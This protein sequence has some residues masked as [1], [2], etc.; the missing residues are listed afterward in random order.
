MTKKFPT[1]SLRR[2]T[3]LLALTLG[4]VGLAQATGVTAQD[5]PAVQDAPAAATADTTEVVIVGTRAGLRKA[6]AVKR[7]SDQFVDSVIAEDIGKLPDVNVA[8][9]LQRVSGVQ[10]K[11]S[12]GEGTQVSIRGLTQNITLVNGR[13]VVDSAGRGGSGV[14]SLGTGSYGLLAQLPSEIIQRL[15]VTKLAAASDIEGALSGTVNIVT[16]KP[17]DSKS[18]TIAF[19]AEGLY[20]NRAGKGGDRTSILFT[21]HFSDKLAG[22]INLSQSDRNIRDESIFS[23]SGYVPLTGAG[24]PTGAYYL[25]DIR[26]TQ[27]NDNR[28]RT[29]LNA[30]LQWRPTDNIEVLYDLLYSKQDIDRKRWWFALPLSSNYGAYTNPVFSPANTL[31]AGSLSASLQTNTETY[32]NSGDT[33]ATGLTGTWK[34]ERLKI[35]GDASYS[36]SQQDGYQQ[37]LR[38]TTKTPSVIAFDFRG[39]DVP[40]FTVPGS[41]NL[42]D[43]SQFNFTNYFDNRDT[44]DS[45]LSAVRLD[46][47]YRLDGPFSHLKFG[48][49]TSQL[50]VSIVKYQSQLTGP[51]SADTVPDSYE[52]RTL[53]ILNGASGYSPQSALYPV[54]FGGGKKYAYDVHGYAPGTFT[55]YIY[56]PLASFDTSEKNTAYYVQTDIDT[57]LFGIPLSGNVGVRQVETKFTAIGSYKVGSN[58]VQPLTVHKD[59]SKTLPS[60]ALKASV[61]DN[62]LIRFGAAKV[63]ARPNS[64]D[65]NPG[66]NLSTAAPFTASA[67]NAELN[68]FEATQYDLSAEYYFKP[69]SIVSLGLFKKDLQSFIIK[70]A[71]TETY[72]GIDYLVTRPYNG[73]DATIDGAEFVYQD[74]FDFLPA[75]FDGLGMVANISIINSDTGTKSVRTG[76]KIPVPGL[77]K[78]NFNLVLYYEKAGYGVRVAYNRRDK[79]LDQLGA[80]GEPIYFDAGDDLAISGRVQITPHY[81][82]DAQIS[83]VLD[84][85]IRKYGTEEVAT[86]SYALNGRTFSIA[87]RGKF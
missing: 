23:F 83:N 75:P 82:L 38:M 60:L 53:D 44:A 18:D 29:G 42:T 86:S 3:S 32:V 68:P 31:L 39:V 74:N 12:L 81:S 26:D 17:L 22:L 63:I 43:P 9:S 4:V 84:S 50:D 59:Y 79:F 51:T 36:R 27:I 8:E 56:V 61:T 49:R 41:V 5:A 46:A 10:I 66:L 30:T 21:H 14:D 87:L 55:P 24:A 77:S 85:P 15:D 16:A 64:A 6:V 37:F 13:D 28:K 58:P 34:G 52:I 73:A 19:S 71:T 1:A 25:A 7:N 35:T 2:H 47:D 80:G 57:T 62:L 33:L 40:Q 72:N 70:K 78:N 20:N 11:R 54:I 69:S 65:Q 48:A 67:G 76:E 45:K